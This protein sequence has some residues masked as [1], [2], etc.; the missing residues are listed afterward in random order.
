[1]KLVLCFMDLEI[2]SR[3]Q[4]EGKILLIDTIPEPTK[5]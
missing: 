5:R 2:P 1:M 4:F 3:D